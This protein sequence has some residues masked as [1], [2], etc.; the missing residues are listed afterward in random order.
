MPKIPQSEDCLSIQEILRLTG[1]GTWEISHY[2]GV[3]PETVTGWLRSKPGTRTLWKN[4]R[5]YIRRLLEYLAL[6]PRAREYFE[7]RYKVFTLLE[8]TGWTPSQLADH[9]MAEREAISQWLYER[10]NIGETAYRFIETAALNPEAKIWFE[11][12][13]KDRIWK[14]RCGD[15]SRL[16]PHS[17]YP[18]ATVHCEGCQCS[19]VLTRQPHGH[20]AWAPLYPGTLEKMGLDK[21][22]EQE[23][24]NCSD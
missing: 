14:C 24:N 11:H 16:K 7:N 19:F 22:Y 12:Y 1:W 21:G 10:E 9:M 20:Y 15:E 18:G 23:K 5:P 6:N 2:I 13:G 8:A 4:A 3:R 17:L